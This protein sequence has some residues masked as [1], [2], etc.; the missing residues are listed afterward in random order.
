VN[1]RQLDHVEMYV[2][3]VRR[4]TVRLCSSFGF[5]PL[6]QGEVAGQR[7]VL[8]GQGDIRLLLT[9]GR[10]AD[11]P[12]TDYVRRHGDGVATI[13]LWTDDTDKAFF[14][15][16]ECGARPIEPPRLWRR[17]DGSEVVTAI[18]SGF[19]D[20]NHRFVQRH[21]GDAYLPGAIEA[22]AFRP[23]GGTPLRAVDHFV[24]CVPAREFAYTVTYY[25]RVFGFRAIFEQRVE[26]GDQAMDCKVIQDPGGA[27]TLTVIAPD[28]SRQP[29]QIDGFLSAH[30]GA[31]VRHIAFRT[32]D[33]AAA[34]SALADRG[35]RF[36]CM[37]SSYCDGIQRRLGDADVPLD[38]LR[39]DDALA[40]RDHWGE[41]FQVFTEPVSA[42]RT[43]FFELIERRGALTFGTEDIEAL[44]AAGDRKRMQTAVGA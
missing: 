13:G 6:G 36:P 44:D 26:I 27:L 7:S 19:G 2:A 29:S 25:R 14:E 21:A 11:D 42:R 22:P 20:V 41:V 34:V 24:V 15:A 1:I 5:Q 38:R 40:G 33:S 31:G 30:G 37:P 4:M 17:L 35:G 3:D 9:S 8:L 18:V 12:A 43:L 32:A 28:P 10:R 23:V 16:V 39:A